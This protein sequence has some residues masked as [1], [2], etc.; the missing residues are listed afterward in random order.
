MKHKQLAINV[1]ALFVLQITNYII[2][3]VT[4]P[5]LVRVLGSEAFGTMSIVQSGVS[6]F[7]ILVDYGFYLSATREVAIRRD[8][9]SSLRRYVSSVYFSKMLF[10]VACAITLIASYWAVPFVHDH[11]E[12]FI[13][14]F[15]AVMA[16][17]L[18]PQWIF[19]GLEEGF[20]SSGFL[21]ACRVFATL[22]VF[23]LVHRPEDI[24]VAMWLNSLGWVLSAGLGI[25]ATRHFIEFKVPAFSAIKKIMSDGWYVFLANLSANFYNNTGTILVGFLLDKSSAGYFSLATRITTAIVTLQTPLSMA[26]FPKVQRAFKDEITPNALKNL[27][28]YLL[29]MM[30]IGALAGAGALITSPYIIPIIFGV[31][32]IEAA[33]LVQTLAF[34]PLFAGMNGI[35][36]SQVLLAR[37]HQK[38]YSFSYMAAA[39]FNGIIVYYFVAKWGEMGA[40]LSLFATEV[41]LASILLLNLRR[42]HI[43]LFPKRG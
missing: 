16:Q 13:A 27:K 21:I 34:L 41:L 14:G 32:Q 7:L 2:P 35:F 12:L 43:F 36:G 31:G 37:G 11:F 5:Y 15:V 42:H 8:D 20:K 38:S 17:S 1:I 10:V 40:A 26:V 9:R 22:L 25:W 29:A 24:N 30:G 39:L 3:L 28:K 6:Y 18:Q 33:P 4:L 19:I 23:P